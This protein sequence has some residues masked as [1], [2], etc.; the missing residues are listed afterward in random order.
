M[1]LRPLI[2]S[3][4]LTAILVLGLALWYFQSKPVATQASP[5]AQTKPSAPAATPPDATVAAQSGVGQPAP[6]ISASPKTQPVLR[7]LGVGGTPVSPSASALQTFSPSVL[8]SAE[9]SAAETAATA[10]MYA[11][12]ASLRTPEVADPDSA[13]NKK[14]LQ[15][16]VLKALSQPGT[17]PPSSST[18]Y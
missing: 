13:A 16:M 17:L 3:F 15:T 5:L 12:H 10:R 6:Q 7:S 11:A 1:K 9:S 4:S 14:I 8:P 18:K 2:I